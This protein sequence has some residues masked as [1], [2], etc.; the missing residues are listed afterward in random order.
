MFGDGPEGV[1]VK[2]WAGL[3][4]KPSRA[5]LWSTNLGQ[6]MNYGL[7]PGPGAVRLSRFWMASS[8]QHNSGSLNFRLEHEVVYV[9]S[10]GMGS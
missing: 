9:I 5:W 7:T 10:S 2:V 4:G 3:L 6:K 1:T 8:C